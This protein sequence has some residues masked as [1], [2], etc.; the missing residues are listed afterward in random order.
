[1]NAR[2]TESQFISTTEAA[3]MLGVS[4]TMVQSLVDSMELVGWKTRGGHRRIALESIAELKN[5]QIVKVGAPPK[6]R[7]LP[8]IIVAVESQALYQALHEALP[9]WRFPFEVKLLD[10]IALALMHLSK[11]RPDMLIA[12]MNMPLHQQERILAALADLNTGGR[13]ISMTLVAQAADVTEKPYQ[14][15]PFI[16]V[17]TGPL[18]L[19]WLEAFLTGVQ[20]TVH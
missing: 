6:A 18:T 7:Q 8:S 13:R 10:S 4:T 11:D 14:S 12:E 1:M 17:I 2:K 16:Q 19:A 20:A 5:K 9:G 15:V 3:N